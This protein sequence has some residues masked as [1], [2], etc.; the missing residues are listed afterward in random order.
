MAAT[1][2]FD[3]AEIDEI[4]KVT[5]ENDYNQIHIDE[6]L[7]L[8]MVDVNAIKAANFNVAIDCVNSVG[9]LILPDLLNRLGEK[10]NKTQL[11]GHRQFCPYTRADT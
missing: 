5:Y 3:Y 1:A 10:H 9:G 7:K 8:K 6:V 11:R 2:D 4:G